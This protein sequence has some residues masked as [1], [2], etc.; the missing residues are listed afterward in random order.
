MHVFEEIERCQDHAIHRA[1]RLLEYVRRTSAAPAG[2]TARTATAGPRNARAVASAPPAAAG[3]AMTRPR[4]QRSVTPGT[5]AQYTQ[6]PTTPTA[7]PAAA[8][9]P[10]LLRPDMPLAPEPGAAQKPGFFSRMGSALQ[11]FGQQLTRK[12]T[13]EKLKMNWHQ[14][15][16]PTDSAAI[17]QFLTT[18][19]VPQ[20]V[21]SAVYQEL[22]LPVPQPTSAQST[23]QLQARQAQ[24]QAQAAAPAQA[25]TQAAPQKQSAKE[26]AADLRKTWTDFEDAGGSTGAPAVTR[27][28]QDMWRQSGGR[29]LQEQAKP[30]ANEFA[31]MLRKKWNDYIQAGGKTT[32]DVVATVR[33]LWMRRGGTKAVYETKKKDA[34][35]HKVKSRYKVWPSAYASGALVQ[36]RKQGADNWGTGGKKK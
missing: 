26:F 3:R 2:T 6:A 7:E 18:Q 31:E 5:V 19:G 22:G 13:K 1:L 15:G 29:Q 27:V 33:D 20:D 34:C 23:A 4:A 9:Q 14:I 17:A 12:V 32:P 24:L 8:A 16:K 35:Y 11:T 36:C 21:I 10:D 30:N 28:I 25:A